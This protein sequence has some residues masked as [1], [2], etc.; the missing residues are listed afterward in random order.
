[1]PDLTPD[2]CVIGAGSAGLSLAAG[3]AQM[4]AA[5]VLVERGR[6]GGECLNTG[7]VPSKALLAAAH[8]AACVRGARAFGID[9][10]EPRVDFAAVR[11]HVQGAID[12]IAPHDS[13][14]RFRGLGVQIIAGTARFLGPDRIA[15]GAD[16]VRA[17]RFVVASGSRPAI[18][19]IPG[20][21]DVA[22]LTNETVFDLDVLPRHLLVIGGGPIGCELAQAF[23]RL[24]AAV[25][26]VEQ[27]TI[28][29][30]DDPELVAVV[31][32]SLEADGVA[33]RE[34]ARVEAIERRRDGLVA[35]FG[36][37]EIAVSH[38]LVAAGRAPVTDGL[39]LAAARIAH[40]ARGITVDSGL[41][42][43]NRRVYAI[44]DVVGG[45][46]F[47]HVANYHAGIVIRR[48]LFRLP[49]RVRLDALPWVT[50]TDPELAQVGMTEAQAKAAGRDPRI[51][52]AE[53][54][55][56]DRA[57]AESRRRGLV[58]LVA[59][60]RGRVL[61]CGIVGACAGELIQLWGLAMN[62]GLRLGAVAGM[63]MP[64][65]TL[66]E[67]SKRAAVSFF[68]PRLF[69]PATRRLVRALGRLP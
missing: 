47:T 55:G 12:A 18:P 62:S 67:A 40:D 11:R 13:V 66:G 25:T 19:P 26:I 36:S 17:R 31:R 1:M 69:G 21:A 33:V 65:P 16:I 8:A 43:T 50:F 49:A 45:A 22:H 60:A 58:K 15:V 30:K 23:R 42:T 59:D 28:L 52:R 32:Q 14:A 53:F 51:L 10:G 35:R 68:T 61:G 54:A 34:G 29:P 39:D 27:A 2:L 6:I 64:Y 37:A 9:A 56:N 44:G 38:V 3:A 24:G 46:L 4:G 63:I 5:V 57:V 7:C 20:L 41:R 48:A